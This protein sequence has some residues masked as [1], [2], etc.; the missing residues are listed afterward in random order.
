MGQGTDGELWAR[1]RRG[2]RTAFEALVREHQAC[3]RRFASGFLGDAAEGDDVAQRTLLDLWVQ[4]AEVGPAGSVRAHL[5]ARA[6][7][8]CLTRARS[9]RRAAHWLARATDE[10]RSGGQTPHDEL[11]AR[12]DIAACA[13]LGAR[14]AALVD[15]LDDDAR[16]GIW[17]RFGAEASFEEIGEVLG[18]PA[19]AV[20][21][22][23]YRQLA[24]LRKKLSEEGS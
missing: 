5:L 8:L 6:R 20:R 15:G 16:T 19:H 3:L 14:V 23:V 9:R 21:A 24:L 12:V 11:A 7:N 17:M 22:L 4:R 13:E 10:P 2:E 1:V 18:R